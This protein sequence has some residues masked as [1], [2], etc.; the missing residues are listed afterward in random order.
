MFP[1]AA[2][3]VGMVGQWKDRERR[4]GVPRRAARVLVQPCWDVCSTAGHTT[5]HGAAR[6]RAWSLGLPQPRDCLCLCFGHQKFATAHSLVLELTVWGGSSEAGGVGRGAGAPEA[7]RASALPVLP[8]PI[9]AVGHGV[10]A[11]C[12]ATNEDRS[13]VFQG[14]SVTGVSVVQ[15]RV[16]GCRQASETCVRA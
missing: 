12:C 3:T 8:E 11:L 2:A 13:W 9:C 1:A 10:A 4:E 15:G 6:A 14:Y 7:S 5:V 16:P